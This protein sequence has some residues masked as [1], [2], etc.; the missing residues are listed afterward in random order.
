MESLRQL[1]EE[2]G[3]P[4]QAKLLAAARKRGLKVSAK[5]VESVVKADSTREIFAQPQ[6]QKGAHATEGENANFQADVVDMKEYGNE[7]KFFLV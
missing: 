5:D 2:L 3:N 4:S 7:D 6:R 1:N